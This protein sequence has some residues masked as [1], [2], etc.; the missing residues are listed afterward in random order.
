MLKDFVRRQLKRLQLWTQSLRAPTEESPAMD[1]SRIDTMSLVMTW[2]KRAIM[3]REVEC[4]KGL[5]EPLELRKWVSHGF[6]K[7]I[8]D[9]NWFWGVWI[10]H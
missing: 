7:L 8:H 2:G 1:A 4:H 5:A 9:F 6:S 3:D 10:H